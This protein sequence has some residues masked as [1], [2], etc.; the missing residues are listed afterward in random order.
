MSWTH[1]PADARV[2]P[3]LVRQDRPVHARDAAPA[4]RTTA[5]PRY[6]KV[7]EK[8]DHEINAAYDVGDHVNVYAGINN[9]FN[10]KPAFGYG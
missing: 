6:F 2:R 5:D 7:K 4:I 10:Q 8:W 1:G 9:L 3:Q